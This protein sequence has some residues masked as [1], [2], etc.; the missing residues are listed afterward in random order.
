[1]TN[2]GQLRPEDDP[3]KRV[4]ID[5]IRSLRDQRDEIDRQ[6]QRVFAEAK[7]AGYKKHLLGLSARL[8]KE[9]DGFVYF[10]AF[11]AIHA[12]K[13][14]WT[15]NM[16]R[17]LQQLESQTRA[18]GRILLTVPGNTVSEHWYQSLFHEHRISSEWFRLNDASLAQVDEVARNPT[19]PPQT[20]GQVI[21]LYLS[22][23]SA[24]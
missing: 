21:D 6:I 2:A 17:R 9:S 18:V 5:R 24:A 13:I 4:F 11:F 10:V 20:G 7:A 19:P 22:G 16:P 8:E 14:G 12:L 1:M 15:R 3:K 23:L